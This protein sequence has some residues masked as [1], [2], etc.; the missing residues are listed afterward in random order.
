MVTPNDRASV[1]LSLLVA[2]AGEGHNRP[3]RMLISRS[4]EGVLKTILAFKRGFKGEHIAVA[5]KKVEPAPVLRWASL[6]DL[7]R[8]DHLKHP[9]WTNFDLGLTM[10]FEA[11]VTRVAKAC[12]PV[13]SHGQ[14]ERVLCG[15]PGSV[16]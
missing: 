16:D 15:E 13:I 5:N 14:C 9:A 8:H 2:R 4:V 3:A 10:E 12:V 6:S 1:L 11:A 7:G